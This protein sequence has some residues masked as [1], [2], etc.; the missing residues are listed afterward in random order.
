MLG[1]EFVEAVVEIQIQASLGTSLHMDFP[2]HEQ[3]LWQ[4]FE[5]R[6]AGRTAV[7]AAQ[8]LLRLQ[9]GTETAVACQA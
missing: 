4:L 5:F 8:D 7:E 6:G 2:T 1:V 3:A 9:E